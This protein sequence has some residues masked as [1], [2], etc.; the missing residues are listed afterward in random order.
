MVG[1]PGELSNMAP[2]TVAL[3]AQAVFLTG[4][5]L[6]LRAPATVLLRRRAVWRAVVRANVVAM[7]AY[8]WHLTALF[9]AVAAAA[10]VGVPSPRWAAG[11]GG[12]GGRCGSRSSPCSPLPS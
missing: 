4:V 7:T 12:S 11:S 6:L 1:L 10:A 2:P 8:L 5:V 3:L 9:V